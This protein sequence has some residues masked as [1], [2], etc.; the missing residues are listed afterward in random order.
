MEIS[1]KKDERYARFYQLV[2]FM[3]EKDEATDMRSMTLQKRKRSWIKMICEH[4]M[5]LSMVCEEK[6]AVVGH[7]QIP[8][9]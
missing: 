1:R 2:S 4:F 7:V 5:K 6:W 8:E 3:S 9:R